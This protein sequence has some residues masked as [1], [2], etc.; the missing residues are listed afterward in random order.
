MALFSRAVAVVGVHG[1]ALSNI[2]FCRDG[3]LI[4]E[5][6]PRSVQSWHY[7][8]AAAALGFEQVRVVRSM[9]VAMC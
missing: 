4:V 6:A 3:T 2:L 8:H 5:I 7:A 1:G 9:C